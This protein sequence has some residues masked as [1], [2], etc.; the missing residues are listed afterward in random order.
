MKQSN[1]LVNDNSVS[2]NPWNIEENRSRKIRNNHMRDFNL[3]QNRSDRLSENQLLAIA[4]RVARICYINESKSIF[5]YRMSLA[6]SLSNGQWNLNHINTL[7]VWRFIS[8]PEMINRLH[9]IG[10]FPSNL[11]MTAIIEANINQIADA[12]RSFAMTELKLSYTTASRH[13]GCA[14]KVFPH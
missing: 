3:M 8:R 14:A 2:F 9:N 13:Y 6:E 4:D 10:I 11:P 1:A 12:I 5:N 7:Q